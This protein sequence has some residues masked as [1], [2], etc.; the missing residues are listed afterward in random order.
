MNKD[1]H[2][3]AANHPVCNDIYTNNEQ[4]KPITKF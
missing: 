4:R 1:L 2:E 3:Y